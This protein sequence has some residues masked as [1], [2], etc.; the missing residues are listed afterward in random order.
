MD[1]VGID[2]EQQNGVIIPV[3][4]VTKVEG[5]IFPIQEYDWEDIEERISP[6][7]KNVMLRINV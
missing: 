1:I 4:K 7:I 2:E 5:S 6:L 3:K